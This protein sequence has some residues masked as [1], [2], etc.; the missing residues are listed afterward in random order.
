MLAVQFVDF[1]QLLVGVGLEQKIQTPLP[2]LAMDVLE[3]LVINVVDPVGQLWR[4]GLD[5]EDVGCRGADGSNRVNILLLVI[6]VEPM[7]FAR[8]AEENVSGGVIS[9]G[10]PGGVEIDQVCLHIVVEDVE[11]GA[12]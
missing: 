4:A 3:Q 2:S 12:A 5:G 8:S 1:G 11:Q 10:L 6:P 7:R 9:L